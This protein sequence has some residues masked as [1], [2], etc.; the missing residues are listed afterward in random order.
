MP[1]PLEQA[2]VRATVRVLETAAFMSVW[3]WTE[4]DGE[5]PLPDVAA[6]ME[7]RGPQPG[8]LTLRVHSSLLPTLIQN[9]LGEPEGS[10]SPEAKTRDALCEVLNMICGNL[11]TAWQGEEAVYDLRPPEMLGAQAPEASPD[12]AVV[13]FVEGTRAVVELR[14]DPPTELAAAALAADVPGEKG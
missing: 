12:A 7:F 4:D 10:E 5:L 9:M 2:V 14:L 11:L 1:E 6:S 3:P 8:S 13:F